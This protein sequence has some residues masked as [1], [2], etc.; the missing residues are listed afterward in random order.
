VS[1]SPDLDYAPRCVGVGDELDTDLLIADGKVYVQSEAASGK[2]QPNH[3]HERSKLRWFQ[4]TRLH[5][6]AL[7]AGY[8]AVFPLVSMAGMTYAFTGSVERALSIMCFDFLTGV[9]IAIPTAVL[10]S[11]YSAGNKGIL[12][13]NASALETLAEIDTV[14]FARSGILTYL[15]PCITDIKVTEGL[16]LEQVSLYAA[17]VERRYDNLAAYAIYNFAPAHNTPIPERFDSRHISGLG[18]EGTVEGHKVIVGRTRLMRMLGIDISSECDFLDLCLKRGDARACVAIDGKLAGVISFYDPLRSDVKEVVTALG[19]LGVSEI[20]MMTGLSD[21][22]AQTL[23]KQAGIKKIHAQTMPDEQAHIVQQYK[24]RGRKVAVVGHDVD[25]ILAL[26]QADLAI[27]LGN[28]SD[29]AR[30]RAD[31]VLTSEALSGLVEGIKIARQG[32]DL[33]RQNIAIVTMP[34]FLGLGLAALGSENFLLAT[35]LNNGSVI[36]ATTNGLKPSFDAGE[37]ADDEDDSPAADKNKDPAPATRASIN[38]ASE[39]GLPQFAP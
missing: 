12:V 6:Q 24:K 23:A 25:D 3:L 13:K 38:E 16:T 29:V 31:I 32:M 33:A 30:L 35:T 19:E 4:H 17:A 21:S 39:D 18:V 2:A 22:A 9:K 34:N 14:I 37:K 15:N 11:M 10:A 7:K 8:K 36:L 27:T 5:R 1:A 28:S 26:E 20:A